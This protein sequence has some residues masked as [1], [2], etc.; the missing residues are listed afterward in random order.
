MACRSHWNRFQAWAQEQELSLPEDL[1]E[2][3]PDGGHRQGGGADGLA[4]S[5]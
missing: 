5:R 1:E 3:L 4:P 2:A